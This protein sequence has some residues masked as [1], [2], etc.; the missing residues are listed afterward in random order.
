MCIFLKELSNDV[1]NVEIGAFYEIQGLL[2]RH[3]DG[4]QTILVLVPSKNTRAHGL[5]LS[6]GLMTDR[7]SSDAR[8]AQR[9]LLLYVTYQYL[10]EYSPRY[11]NFVVVSLSS[12]W[13]AARSSNN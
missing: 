4:S 5:P 11:D 7:P 13:I 2:G 9:L 1:R 8:V 6:R 12:P 10:G 3:T